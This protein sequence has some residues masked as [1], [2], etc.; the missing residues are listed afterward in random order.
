MAQWTAFLF[1]EFAQKIDCP[2]LAT[3]SRVYMNIFPVDDDL[4]DIDI[5]DGKAICLISFYILYSYTITSVLA[6]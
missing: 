6:I 5:L 4:L 3:E 1:G 2:I